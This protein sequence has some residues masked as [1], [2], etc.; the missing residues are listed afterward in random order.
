MKLFDSD[1]DPIRATTSTVSNLIHIGLS[2]SSPT[3]MNP[4]N[5][6]NTLSV[7][8]PRGFQLSERCVGSALDMDREKPRALPCPRLDSVS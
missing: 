6:T 1:F 5:P 4:Q 7:S 8:P 3:K 2:N